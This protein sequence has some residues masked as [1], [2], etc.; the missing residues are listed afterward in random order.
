MKDVKFFLPAIPVSYVLISFFFFREGWWKMGGLF[1]ALSV[2]FGMLVIG[3]AA[4][5]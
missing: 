4:Q 1:L 3:I 2:V 5:K